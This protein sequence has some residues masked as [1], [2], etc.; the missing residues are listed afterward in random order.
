MNLEHIR[1]FLEV[2][3]TGNLNKAADRL[4]VTQSTVTARINALENVI[5]QRLLRRNKSG[6]ELTAAGYKFLRHAKSLLQIWNQAR[7]DTALPKGF[8]DICTLGCLDALWR[9]AGELWVDQLRRAQPMIAIGAWSGQESDL[10]VWLANGI[11]DVAL[12]Y[13]PQVNGSFALE[14]A[15]EDVFAQFSTVERGLQR[16]DPT[17]VFVDL[18]DEFRRGHAET[19][20]VDET[21]VVSFNNSEHA[22]RHILRWGGSAYLPQRV[23]RDHVE[24]GRLFEVTGA[25]RFKRTAY[26]AYNTHRAQAW[27]WFPTFADNFL[28]ALKAAA[29]SDSHV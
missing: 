27:P 22:L 29:R 28:A 20:P 2:V 24:S 12:M 17:Y 7:H 25:R 6:T 14:P 15:F 4:Y 8:D 19:Y 26:L 16:W 5:G 1:T 9:G 18:G 13:D 23:A 10:Q 21:A 11:A 3:E